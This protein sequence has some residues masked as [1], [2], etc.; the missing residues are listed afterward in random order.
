MCML[1]VNTNLSSLSNHRFFRHELFQEK[2]QQAECDRITFNT[3]S[4]KRLTQTRKTA[5]ILKANA[6]V[7]KLRKK[8]L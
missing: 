3:V 2:N 6:Q 7:E 5:K 1:D 4:M 8:T